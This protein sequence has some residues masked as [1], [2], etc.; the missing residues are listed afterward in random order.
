[1]FCL[2]PLSDHNRQQ[3]VWMSPWTS[4]QERLKRRALY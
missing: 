2:V 1:L 3:S 4:S